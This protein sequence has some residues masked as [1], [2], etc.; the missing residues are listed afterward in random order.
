MD[1]AEPDVWV[2]AVVH[3]LGSGSAVLRQWRY[4]SVPV[5]KNEG[6]EWIRGHHTE[7]SPEGQAM[8]AANAVAYEANGHRLARASASVKAGDLL[9]LRFDGT[10]EP[11]RAA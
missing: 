2:T 3:Q 1:A 11:A 7:D 5:W 8:L 6:V 4:T 10:V 9:I